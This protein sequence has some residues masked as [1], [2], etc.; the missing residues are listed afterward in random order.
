MLFFQKLKVSM[1]AIFVMEH[2]PQINFIRAK[3]PL[4]YFQFNLKYIK[5]ELN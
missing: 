5:S 4:S 1:T 2:T 3:C